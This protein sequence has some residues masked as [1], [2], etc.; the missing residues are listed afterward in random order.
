MPKETPV[1]ANTP[2]PK[3]YTFLSRG[4][5][6]K[7]LHTRKLTHAHNLPLYT[8]VDPKSNKTLGLRAPTF[9]V[10]QVHVQAKSTLAKRRATVFK[11]D[12]ADLK[13]A[14]AA[15]EE[16][17]TRIPEKDKEAV[18]KHGFRKSSG[19]VGRTAKL[20][21]GERAVLAVKAHVRHK[22]TQYDAIIKQVG[23]DKARKE[24]IDE[25]FK[26]VRGW[27]LVAGMKLLVF[28]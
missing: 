16:R 9:I 23:K 3:K 12:E 24:T 27:G 22:Y 2:L 1:P 15:L 7:T 8:V 6:Y 13:K 28:N 21:L 19:R 17:F 14:R 4:N 5:T 18:L 25:V 20:D 11:R 26:I 10:E